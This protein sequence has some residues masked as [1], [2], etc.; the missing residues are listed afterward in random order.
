MA[1]AIVGAVWQSA[2]ARDNVELNTAT[3]R[4]VVGRAAAQGAHIVVFPELF[5]TNYNDGSSASDVL[6]TAMRLDDRDGPLAAI[7]AAAS[8]HKIAVAVGFPELD[9]ARVF[10]SCALWD[11]HGKLVKV[12]VHFMYSV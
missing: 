8:E 12:R 10:N 4:E 7:A 5:L 6:A 9:D 11:C 2:A 1:E 3:V